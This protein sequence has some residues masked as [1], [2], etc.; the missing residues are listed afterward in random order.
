MRFRISPDMQI[1]LGVMT[2]VPQEAMAGTETELFKCHH[3]GA[4]EMGALQP[5]RRRLEE[6]LHAVYGGGLFGSGTTY[7]HPVSSWPSAAATLPCG[8]VQ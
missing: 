2:K 1:A 5:P 6:K 4:D 7:R 8:M 3:S